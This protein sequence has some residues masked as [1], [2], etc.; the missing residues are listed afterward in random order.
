MM[1]CSRYLLSWNLYLSIRNVHI[2]IPQSYKFLKNSHNVNFSKSFSKLLNQGRMLCNYTDLTRSPKEDLTE[3]ECIDYSD[4]SSLAI[5]E[6]VEKQI[7]LILMEYE[8]YKQSGEKMPSTIQLED[9]KELLNHPVERARRRY[10]HYLFKREKAKLAEKRRKERRK[11]ERE[12]NKLVKSGPKNTFFLLIRKTSM[13][14]FYNTRQADAV[15]FGSS[16]VIDM[17]YDEY[18]AKRELINCVDQLS[19][20]YGSNKINREPFNLYFCNLHKDNALIPYL[21][22]AIPH[23]NK[24]N[25]LITSTEKSYLDIFPKERI[26][27]LT[28]N[29]PNV[30]QKFDHDS[31]YVIGGFVDKVNAKPLSLAKAKREGLK[32][33][34]LPLDQHLH[35]GEGCKSLTINQVIDILL[36][37]KASNNWNKAFEFVPNRK[38]RKIDP[39]EIQHQTVTKKKKQTIFN[40]KTILAD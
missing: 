12:Q 10:F 24:N 25:C 26:V 21:N 28:P 8:I 33:A 9:M 15:M 7:K 11:L 29:S 34:K 1:K 17:A 5:T 38:I 36:E 30:L 32:T 6:D 2:Y 19:M 40:M 37:V 22:N 14:K 20:A 27:Y 23:I 13:L 4:F 16:L 31:V 18:M 39:E 3:N 35:W